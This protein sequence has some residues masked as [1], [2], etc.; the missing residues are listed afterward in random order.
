MVGALCQPTMWRE[1][2]SMKRGVH[3]ARPGRTVGK[4]RDSQS[5]WLASCDL[6][7]YQIRRSCRRRVGDGRA[8]VLPRPAPVRSAG[9]SAAPPCI[10][11]R[12]CVH[13]AVGATFSE[14][15]R[16]H[17]FQCTRWISDFELL[18]RSARAESGRLSPHRTRRSNRQF[19]ADRLDSERLFVTID[20][21]DYFGSRGSSFPRKESQ[22]C[23]QDLIRAA[24]LAILS[25]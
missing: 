4:A 15:C 7:F 21:L 1:N 8:A 24:Q 6:S 16:C 3:D 2:A 12:Q 9:A 10:A 19:C 23:F 5:L 22:R 14:R 25:V 17:S 11:P 18:S 13:G 20:K